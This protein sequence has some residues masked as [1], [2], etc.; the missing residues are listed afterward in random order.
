M[1]QLIIKN[2]ANGMIEMLAA[3]VNRIYDKHTL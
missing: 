1:E 3:I 2:M